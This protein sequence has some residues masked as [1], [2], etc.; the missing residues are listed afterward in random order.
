MTRKGEDGGLTLAKAQLSCQP[1]KRRLQIGAS[2]FI[3]RR[4]SWSREA[5]RGHQW[6]RTPW[7]TR[8]CPQMPHRLLRLGVGIEVI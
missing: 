6:G 1:A 8:E 5:H 7:T 2:R 4:F 3:A